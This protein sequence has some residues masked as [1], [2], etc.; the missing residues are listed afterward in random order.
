M[1]SVITA[2]NIYALNESELQRRK[3][4]QSNAIVCIEHLYQY[5]QYAIDIVP[6]LEISKLESI[7]ELM[8]QVSTDL[9]AWKKSSKIVSS[10]NQITSA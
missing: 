9:K 4:F 8:A 1:D 5:L 2:N 6:D 3:Q 10:N 7:S